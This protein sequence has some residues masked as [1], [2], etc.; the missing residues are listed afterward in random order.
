[1]TQP[2][3]PSDLSSIQQVDNE[4]T[5]FIAQIEDGNAPNP[6][7]LLKIENDLKSLV[8]NAEIPDSV[9][10]SLNNA[11]QKITSEESSIG[12]NIINLESLHNLK[13]EVDDAI[14]PR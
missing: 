12:T 14:K 6:A 7:R 10:K 1:M 2:I 13:A 5:E 9:K 11:L 8:N 4:I 3:K